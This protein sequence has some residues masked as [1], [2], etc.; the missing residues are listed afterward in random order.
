MV[1][2]GKR[3]SS[4]PAHVFRHRRSY[5]SPAVKKLWRMPPERMPMISHWRRCHTDTSLYR[6]TAPADRCAS[7]IPRLRHSR[8]SS[9]ERLAVLLRI[10]VAE[11]TAAESISGMPASCAKRKSADLCATLTHADL[12]TGPVAHDARKTSIQD[13]KQEVLKRNFTCCKPVCS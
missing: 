10:A 7:S 3:S 13:G 9:F 6:T 5:S 1:S 4:D 8:E 12:K 2:K 11:V